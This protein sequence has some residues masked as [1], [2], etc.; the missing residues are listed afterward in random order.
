[1][2]GMIV[3]HCLRFGHPIGFLTRQECER[4]GKMS[5]NDVYSARNNCYK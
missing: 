4:E 3:C 2:H 1:M 5:I